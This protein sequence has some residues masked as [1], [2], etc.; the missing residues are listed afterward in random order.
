MASSSGTLSPGGG[1]EGRTLQM[2]WSLSS[3]SVA[4][5]YS[6]INWTLSAVGGS[7]SY[8]YHHKEKLWIYGA[9]R[10]TNTSNTKRYKGTI[11]TGSVTISHNDVGDAT[12]SAELYGAIYTSSQNVSGSAS[13]TLPRIARASSMTCPA[14]FTVSTSG[15]ITLSRNASSF[16]H[17]ASNS[18]GND[19]MSATSG[20]ATSFTYTPPISLFNS[21]TYKAN[22]TRSG[23]MTVQ[24]KS[25]S[26]NIGSA[27]T[28]NFTVK[29]PENDTTK[30]TCT[31]SDQLEEYQSSYLSQY[32]VLIAGRSRL[33]TTCT[34]AGKVSATVASHHASIPGSSVTVDSSNNVIT[35]YLKVSSSQATLSYYV[36][37]TRGF[38]SK[39]ATVSNPYKVVEY[40]T[41]SIISF[42]AVRVDD[43]GN[44]DPV[45]GTKLKF[46]VNYF[47][48][49]IV[50][51]EEHA[52]N[53]NTAT[54]KI[55]ALTKDDSGNVT[56]RTQLTASDGSALTINNNEFTTIA[57]GT[58]SI[59][60]SFTFEATIVDDLT[61]TEATLNTGAQTE[62]LTAKALMSFYKSEGLT[63]G[64]VAEEAGLHVAMD[65]TFENDIFI[66]DPELEELWDAL[67]PSSSSSS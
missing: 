46:K 61:T 34:S 15:T 1:Y 42:T 9:W 51:D 24:T 54:L 18:L 8:Y 10:Y 5:N 23:T 4:G 53:A 45:N 37:D 14:N 58:Y 25:G 21:S 49:P 47:V 57:S 36:K 67:N 60:N 31:L 6:V 39:T 17:T 12:F 13:W 33:K 26:T 29:L 44:E 43:N 38:K 20:I 48:D 35:D 27:L 41:P 32:G 66:D 28:A 56:S 63:I 3:Q 59:A 30:P 22:T 50:I 55:Y 40:R 62:V 52:D 7:A 65:A 64:R 2:S 16:T 19:G 11:K